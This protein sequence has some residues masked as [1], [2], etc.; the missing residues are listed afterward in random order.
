MLDFKVAKSLK[1]ANSFYLNINFEILNG[2]KF[3]CKGCFVEKN[4]QTPFLKENLE[5]L[6]STLENFSKGGYQPFLAFLGPTDFLVSSNLQTVF[7]NL[8][9]INILKKFKRIVFQTTFVDILNSDTAIKIINDHF[10]DH[11]IE[12]NTVFEPF[13]INNKVA[14]ENVLKNQQIFF[15]K[16]ARSDVK[17]FTIFNV[18]NYQDAKQAVILKDYAKLDGLVK[19]IFR[20]TID[21][22]F[23]SGRN[24]DLT[25][26]EFSQLTDTAK[27]LFDES[28]VDSASAENLRFSFGKIH[29]SLLEVQLNYRG[30]SYYYSP[31]LYERFVSFS[32]ELKVG[33]SSLTTSAY[34]KYQRDLVLEQYK[35]S[36]AADSCESCG[37]LG[38][39]V[40]RGI[41]KLM[42]MYD[43]KKCIVAKKAWEITSL[44]SEY[45]G[46]AL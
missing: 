22:N 43:V 3:K 12:I 2:C 17:S 20:T 4:A 15:S 9:F 37:F 11:E 38:I 14:V 44:H 10:K 16:L 6:I 23:S 19:D 31:L 41:L 35:Y 34:E 28:I 8:E 30:G 27:K 7:D 18:Y 46:G 5:G 21:Y 32:D 13:L 24:K 26:S 29:D 39:C 42:K 40:D 45:Q 1:L 33:D 25:S 36:Q